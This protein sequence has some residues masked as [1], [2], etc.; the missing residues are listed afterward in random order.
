MVL[1][2]PKQGVRDEK[3]AHLIAAIVEHHGAPFA[4][5]ALAP[6]GVFVKCCAVEEDQ[7]VSVFW[8]MARHPIDN[9][10]DTGLVAGVNEKFE[11]IGCAKARSGSIVSDYLVSP[12]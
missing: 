5:L 6:V 11:V 7:A 1:L 8:E 9:H 4:V 3:R 2:Q 10:S 12:G